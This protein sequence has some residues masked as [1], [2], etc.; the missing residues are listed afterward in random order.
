MLNFLSILT[1]GRK[2]QGAVKDL[3]IEELESV[4]TKLNTIIDARKRKEA[5][6]QQQEAAKKEKLAD[7]LQ[8]MQDAG[9]DVAD[10]HQVSQKPAPKPQKKRPVKYQ[11]SDDNGEIHQWTGIGRM[12]KVYA[13]A[14]ASGK[15]LE[16]FL[17]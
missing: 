9:L 1:H 3:S 10:L 8:Q 5:Q 15:K 14:I 16:D 12:P 7:I 11:I 13:K 17:I 2:L 6:L 4:A